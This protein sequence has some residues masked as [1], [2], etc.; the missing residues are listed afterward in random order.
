VLAHPIFVNKP[1]AR[2]L[3]DCGYRQTARIAPMIV[4]PTIW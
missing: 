2:F 3:P 1:R 4:Q